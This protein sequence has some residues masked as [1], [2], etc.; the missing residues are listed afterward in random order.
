M[1]AIVAEHR[2]KELEK[3]K[4]IYQWYWIR[5]NLP[6]CVKAATYSDLPRNSR[7]SDEKLRLVKF[8]NTDQTIVTK[9]FIFVLVIFQHLLQIKLLKT[10]FNIAMCS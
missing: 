2:R 7:F 4:E 10:S 6:G 8:K 1:P 3:R 5:D 9:S